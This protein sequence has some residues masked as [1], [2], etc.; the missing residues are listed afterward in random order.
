EY[1]YS[2]SC[3]HFDPAV[4]GMKH[5]SDGSLTALN[6]TLPLPIAPPSDF[7]CPYLAAADPTTHL[8]IAVQPLTG[9]WDS[10]GP[11][12]LATY[13]VNNS[14]GNLTTSSTYKNMPKVLVGTVADYWMS[15]SGKFLAV[16]GTA[17]LQ[18]FHFN[19]A[20]PITKY[21]GLL[22]TTGVDQIFWDNA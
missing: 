22:T 8:A 6:G 16:G 4:F 15:P 20:K 14:S 21:T 3:Y 13:T 19:G 17:G 1:A 7:Y 18:I 9:N 2:S 11:W 12:Q 5:N 10:A